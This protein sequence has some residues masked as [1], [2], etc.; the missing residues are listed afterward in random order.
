MRIPSDAEINEAATRLGLDVDGVCP[1]SLRGRVA[2]TVQVA[3]ADTAR[4]DAA[5][6]AAE[7]V[8]DELAAAVDHIA[9][10]YTQLCQRI[11]EQAAREIT[12]GLAPTLYRAASTNRTPRK[13]PH[14]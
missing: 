14:Q 8:T 12:A 7:S 10:A 3:A 4:T 1:P 13:E 11:P 9:A 6:A 2:R 5:A